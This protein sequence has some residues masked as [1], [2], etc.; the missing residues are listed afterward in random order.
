LALCSVFTIVISTLVVISIIEKGPVVFLRKAE[1]YHGQIDAFV[2]AQ[3]NPMV[4]SLYQVGYLNYTTVYNMTKD[5]FN[6]SPRKY[7]P[8]VSLRK[9]EGAV[10]T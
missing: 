10:S 4:D 7:Y 3:G 6:L 5:K 2:S 1:Y 8:S 9:Y